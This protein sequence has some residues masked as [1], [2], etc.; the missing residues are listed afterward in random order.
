MFFLRSCNKKCSRLAFSERRFVSMV[1][2]DAIPCT[3]L[4]IHG[5]RAQLCVHILLSKWARQISIGEWNA[6]CQFVLLSCDAQIC[7]S[8]GLYVERCKDTTIRTENQHDQHA[9]PCC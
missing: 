2:N 7:G 9:F 4:W 6:F 8:N 1:F 3:I 5:E